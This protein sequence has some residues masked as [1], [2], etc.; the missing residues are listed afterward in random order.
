MLSSFIYLDKTR[1]PCV[2]ARIYVRLLL[3]EEKC[4]LGAKLPFPIYRHPCVFPSITSRSN[5]QPMERKRG[6]AKQRGKTWAKQK[7][8]RPSKRAN[9]ARGTR[10]RTRSTGWS[11]V[12][13]C[14]L[15]GLQ[16]SRQNA[17]HHDLKQQKPLLLARKGQMTRQGRARAQVLKQVS[18]SQDGVAQRA[19]GCAN[20]CMCVC[21]RAWR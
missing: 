8:R 13:M 15:W 5:Q 9:E 16:P 19:K 1:R 3:W 6:Q 20:V 2:Y 7:T 14:P 18:D 11:G 4:H 17:R 12:R 21:V 10:R